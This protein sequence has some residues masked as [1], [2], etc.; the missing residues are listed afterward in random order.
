MAMMR[1]AIFG[2]GS[3]GQRTCLHYKPTCKVVAFLD[4]D[5][6]KHGTRVLGVPVCDPAQFRFDDVD[7]VLIASMYLDQILV[8]LLALGVP[9]STI[10][11]VSDDVMMREGVSG[12]PGF[13]RLVRNLESALYLPFRLLRK[14]A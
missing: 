14:V 8:Q 6:A 7:Q 10:E 9:S 1:V 12:S 4:N 2:C 3:A 5:R 13:P 11:Y